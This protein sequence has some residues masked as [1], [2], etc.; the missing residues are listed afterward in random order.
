MYPIIH[1]M[2]G[3]AYHTIFHRSDTFFILPAPWPPG[4]VCR[5]RQTPGFSTDVLVNAP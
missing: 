1:L 3:E 2:I 4:Y 5:R